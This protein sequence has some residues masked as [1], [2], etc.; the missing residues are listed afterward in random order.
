MSIHKDSSWALAKTAVISAVILICGFSTCLSGLSEVQD[1]PYIAPTDTV[2]S[3]MMKEDF[4]Y[5][6]QKLRNV[7]PQTIDGFS[8]IQEKIISDIREKIQKPLTKEAFFFLLNELFHSFHDAHTTL[9][10]VFSQGI[11]LPLIWLQDGLYVVRD[12]DLLKQGDL[13]QSIGGQTVPQ[14]F[15]NLHQILWTENSH[16]VRL[17]GPWMLS[18]RPYLQ[19]LG[20]IE[21]AGVYVTY[22][23]AGRNH[24][25]R[26]PVIKLE[27]PKNENLPFIFHTID[28]QHNLAVL[29]L[30]SCRFNTEYFLK[31]RGFFQDVHGQQIDNIALDLRRNDGG[32]SRVID[33]FLSYLDIDRIKTYGSWVRYS[34]EARSLT[35]VQ[36]SGVEEFP[37]S[38]KD[39]R[40]IKDKELIFSGRLYVLTSPN[41]FSSANMFAATLQDN[42]ICI[43]VG[44]PTGNQPSC[45]GH[46]L[47]FEMPR[48]GIYFKISH[49]QFFRPD[50]ALDQLDAV[51]PD[52]K[53]YRKIDDV[54]NNKDAQMEKILELIKT[55]QSKH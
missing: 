14:L 7:H 26:L 4:E 46:P 32:D 34:Q 36:K 39:N 19:H 10:L 47:P 28:K 40:K 52:I 43:V 20:L 12:T 31:L 48:T 16:L 11:D 22:Q 41:T 9:W 27:R 53:V 6:V 17:E 33:L 2:S 49:K 8:E 5:I 35:N 54:I 21:P 37:R 24:T 38:E 50:S 3:D 30:N 1:K 23:R 25:V 44:E 15:D 29:T 18:A 42:R 45:F 55:H 51:Y 13:I